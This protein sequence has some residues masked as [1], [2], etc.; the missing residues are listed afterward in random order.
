MFSGVFWPLSTLQQSSVLRF[1]FTKTTTDFKS[2]NLGPQTVY[3]VFSGPVQQ[4]L[5]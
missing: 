2:P 1:H 3:T 4:S 5:Y